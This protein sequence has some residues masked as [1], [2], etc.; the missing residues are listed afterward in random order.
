MKIK[1][2]DTVLILTGKDKGKSG[3]VVRA[4]PKADKVV[5]EGLNTVKRHKR[6][7][8]SNQKGE[9]IVVAMPIH[10]SNVKLT[11]ASEKK[12]DKKVAKAKKTK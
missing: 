2:N 3:V 9:T 6:A 5:I 4:L 8:L 11:G 7:R 1:K 10:V 12:A